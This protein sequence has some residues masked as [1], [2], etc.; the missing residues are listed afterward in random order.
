LLGGVVLPLGGRSSFLIESAD[1][2]TEIVAPIFFFG[3][4]WI[5]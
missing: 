2:M 4:A 3:G 1:S 5:L